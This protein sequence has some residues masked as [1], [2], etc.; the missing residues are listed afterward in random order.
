MKKVNYPSGILK[1]AW[2]VSGQDAR[3]GGVTLLSVESSSISVICKSSLSVSK[4][5][6]KLSG[7]L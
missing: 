1:V 5:D 4:E 6:V 2:L 7:G 3:E